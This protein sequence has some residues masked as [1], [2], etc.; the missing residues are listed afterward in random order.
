MRPASVALCL[1]VTLMIAIPPAS[2]HDGPLDH[3]RI[4]HILHYGYV[5]GTRA[6]ARSVEISYRDIA[7]MND[8]Y[9]KWDAAFNAS[10]REFRDHESSGKPLGAEYVLSTYIRHLRANGIGCGHVLWSDT[11]T[12]KHCK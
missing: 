8:F 4:V 1:A 2:G 12:R 6:M 3:K 9:R 10:Q 5:M 7:I 11:K